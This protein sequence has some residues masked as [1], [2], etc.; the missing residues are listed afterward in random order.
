MKARERAFLARRVIPPEQV[1]ARVLRGIERNAPRVVVGRD[2]R[3]V[4]VIVRL[5]PSWSL[6]RLGRPGRRFP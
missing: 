3:M 2:Y 5:A 4:D 6:E 1:A